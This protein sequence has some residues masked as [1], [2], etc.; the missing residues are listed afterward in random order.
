[1]KTKYILFLLTVFAVLSGCSKNSAIEI[2]DWDNFQ[3]PIFKVSFMYPKD[4]YVV[5]E[6]NRIL[7]Y[8]SMEVAEKFFTRDPRKSDGVQIIVACEQSDTIQDYVKFIDDYKTD[9]EAAG[10]MIKAVADA[11]IE[12]LTAKQVTYTGAYDEQTKLTAVRAATLK[13][14][15]IYYVQYAGFN[16]M[17]DQYRTVYDSLIATLTLPKPRVQS[18]DP[19]SFVIPSV[20]TKVIKNNVLEVTIPDNMN[21]TYP[22]LK[23]EVNFAMNLKIYRN[24]CT[25]DIDTRPAKNLT[26]EKVIEQNSKKI[27][28]VTGKGAI[29]VSGEKAQ[30]FHYSLRKGIKSRIYFIVKNDKIYRIIMSY[31]GPMEKDFLPAFEKIVASI[32]IK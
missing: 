11:K 20:D 30:Y 24:D 25:I 3:D 8:N 15:A 16:K 12:G 7:I 1:M 23:G 4:W 27:S 21:E 2:K 5:K 13:D 19:N 28:N 32:R 17:Y 26:L 6:P 18:K 22:T 29:T 10:F 9:Q 14:S 31:Y